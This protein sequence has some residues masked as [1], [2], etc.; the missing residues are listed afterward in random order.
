MMIFLTFLVSI[1]DYLK[2]FPHPPR[3]CDGNFFL[4]TSPMTWWNCCIFIYS[5]KIIPVFQPVV[6]KARV[7]SI[8][9]FL[10]HV[11]NYWFSHRDE[12]K[13]KSSSWSAFPSFA[14][15]VVINDWIVADR[16]VTIRKNDVSITRRSEQGG[17]PLSRSLDYSWGNKVICNWIIK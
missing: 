17:P 5:G 15:S 16:K 4:R 10:V 6:V 2:N 9:S 13:R 12:R 1:T 7:I 3:S 11:V 14:K 8:I